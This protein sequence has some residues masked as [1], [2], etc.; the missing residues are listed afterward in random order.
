MLKGGDANNS[1]S[2][3][4]G[5]ASCIGGAYG[6]APVVSTCGGLGSPDVNGDG[7]VDILDLTLMGGNFGIVA[8]P[9]TP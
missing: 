1:E 9:W 2:I 3:E 8:S 5:D 4:V 6:V 7:K